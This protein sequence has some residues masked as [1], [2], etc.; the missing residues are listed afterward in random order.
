MTYQ[1]HVNNLVPR[2]PRQF[3]S[4]RHNVSLQFTVNMYP[5]LIMF[6][7]QILWKKGGEEENKLLDLDLLWT[8]RIGLLFCLSLLLQV[9]LPLLAY[10]MSD[11]RITCVN[12]ADPC[13]LSEASRSTKITFLA[14]NFLFVKMISE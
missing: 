11:I 1:T 6:S 10:V 3:F 2:V 7:K 8:L 4:F 14:E 12:I 13:I 5:P 9:Y